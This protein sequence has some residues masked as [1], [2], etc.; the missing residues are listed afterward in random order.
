MKY[1]ILIVDDEEDILEFLG[2]NLRNQGWEIAVAR[3]GLEALKVADEFCPHLILM[4]VM[5]PDMD[6][7]TACRELRQKEGFANT[8]VA[9][10]TARGE[11]YSQIAGFEAGA[12]D[13]IAKPIRPMVLVSRIN[14]LLKRLEVVKSGGDDSVE[15]GKSR[16][17]VDLERH[18]VLV[19]GEEVNLPRKEFSLLSLLLT[20]PGRVFSRDEIYDGVWGDEVVVGDRTI[21]VHIRKLRERFGE[22]LIQTVKGVGYKL[23]L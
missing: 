9:M 19:G 4:D 15:G 8:I 21:D 16:I 5:M 22:E 2:Y 1:R 6:G 14:A 13:Y 18:V 23:V 20:K 7:I 3:S 10:L 12:D 11:D 17:S